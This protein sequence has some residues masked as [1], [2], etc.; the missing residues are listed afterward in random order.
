MFRNV[1]V[2]IDGSAHAARALSEAV[3]LV[4]ATNARLTV[5]T[6]VPNASSWLLGMGG[7]STA[8]PADALQDE[9]LHEYRALL[10]HA[11]DA[12]PADLPVTK[13]LTRG[14]A[15]PAIVA[16]VRAGGH[17]LVVMGSRGRGDVRSLVLGSVSHQVL[18]TSPAAVLVVHAADP[19]SGAAAA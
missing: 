15:A 5:M 16:Q 2:A 12:L 11:I 17:D 7:V 19:D 4:R 8:E 13:L 9:M 1:L 3:D 10:D 14:R 6:S 18:Q